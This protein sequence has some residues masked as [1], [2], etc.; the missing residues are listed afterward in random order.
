MRAHVAGDDRVARQ[1]RS[2][3]PHH[4]VRRQTGNLRRQRGLERRSVIGQPVLRPLRRSLNRC[5]QRAKRTGDI[6]HDLDPRLIDPF[7]VRD[8]ID[9]DQRGIERPRL[10]QLNHVETGGDDQIRL[11]KQAV[12]DL[13][14][15]HV[16]DP[17]GQAVIFRKHSLR[18]RR[19]DDRRPQRLGEPNQGGRCPGTQRADPNGDRRTAGRRQQGRG[20]GHVGRWEGRGF[21]HRARRAAELLA[22]HVTR[23]LQMHRSRALGGSQIV[24]VLDRGCRGIG[25]N[26]NRRLGNR[27]VHRRH[28]EPLVGRPNLAIGG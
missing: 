22:G 10:D 28:V 4:G 7:D 18:L 25:G 9:V 2:Q 27:R 26:P 23:N 8:R 5:G 21:A 14:A 15:G 19:G 17:G 12:Y 13:F 1:R 20:L 16:N 24:G 11:G 6:P 3:R